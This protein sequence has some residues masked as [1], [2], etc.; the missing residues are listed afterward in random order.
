MKRRILCLVISAGIGGAAWSVVQQF[1]MKHPASGHSIL[2]PSHNGA[3]ALLISGWKTTPAGRHITSGDMILSGEISPDGRLF[4]F[5]NT[6]YTGHYMHIVDLGSEKEIATFPV[7]QAWS[8]LAWAPDSKRVY[9]YAG[10]NPV[11]SDILP[12]V[13]YDKEGWQGARG[14]FNLV[15]ATNDNSA[16]SDILISTDGTTLYAINNSDGYLYVLET[17][18]G[19]A[20]SR[21]K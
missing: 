16:V 20:L 4:A 9:V 1:R 3:N 7:I 21:L 8:G 15:G 18:G 19:R 5:T 12:F 14:G 10:G 2:V 6:G 13:H 17:F 11:G